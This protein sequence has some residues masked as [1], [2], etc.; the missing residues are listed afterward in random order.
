VIAV[1]P[2]S[3]QQ[4]GRPVGQLDSAQFDISNGGNTAG[5]VSPVV[6]CVGAG[7]VTGSCVLT[8][9]GNFTVPAAPAAGVTRYVRYQRGP[10]G[11]TTARISFIA[12]LVGNS[13]VS[14]TGHVDVSTTGSATAVS[15]TP[16]DSVLVNVSPQTPLAAAFTIRNTS[17]GTGS[18]NW[19]AQC[20][21]ASP[22]CTASDTTPTLG[23]NQIHVVN[24]SFQVNVPGDSGRITLL[25][26]VRGNP[27]V[28]DSGRYT[29]RSTGQP[30][31][32][33]HLAERNPGTTV[34]REQC[35][36]VA[37][38]DAASECGAL[39]F[40]HAL[41]VTRTLGT[42]R[43]PVLLYNSQLAHPSPVITV[44][45]DRAAG[46]VGT[47]DSLVAE[48]RVRGV[49]KYRKALSPGVLNSAGYG[50]FHLSYD[51]LADTTGVYPIAV[52]VESWRAGHPMDV[53]QATLTTAVVNRSASRFGP[54]WWMAGVERL[55]RVSAAGDS[56]LW[57]GGDGSARLY[58]VPDT[59]HRVY[60]AESVSAPDSLVSA[61]I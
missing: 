58:T 46:A 61:D 12:T 24:R 60:R 33:L 52:S 7:I 20:T 31:V 39:R 54:G 13:A 57:I 28:V 29:A 9:G 34:P 19:T 21:L 16:D 26:S 49:P 43:A 32:V 4:L 2:K 27:S 48:L 11:G 22:A 50:R 5:V 6:Q 47:F 40:A 37:L 10:T 3:G 55:V 8:V 17:A 51:A 41:P 38:G 25:A 56:I 35:L 15:V 1:A 59:T 18:F 42:V 44:D 30:S 45:V 53:A 36:L 14:D 23:P